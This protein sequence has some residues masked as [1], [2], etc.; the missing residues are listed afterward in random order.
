MVDLGSFPAQY[1]I[2]TVFKIVVPIYDKGA[3]T[4]MYDTPFGPFLGIGI[5]QFKVAYHIWP[6]CPMM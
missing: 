1:N 5:W 6:T 3:N 2:P 4:V